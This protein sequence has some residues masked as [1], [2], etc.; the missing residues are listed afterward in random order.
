MA[1]IRQCNRTAF[2]G[3]V[4]PEAPDFL[5]L[6]GDTRGL[7]GLDDTLVQEIE[8]NLVVRS[9]QAFE[10]KFAPVAYSFFSVE[11]Q[12][13]IYTLERP[14][15]HIIPPDYLTEIPL[16]INN[17]TTGMMYTML[18]SKASGGFKNIE[19]AYEN[20]LDQISPKKMVQNVKQISKELR[21]NYS[22]YETLPEWDPV[23]SKKVRYE[24]GY[25]VPV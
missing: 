19:F 20:I 14:A 17:P 10:R 13:P 16:G 24:S 22:K 1:D 5:T 23:K 25:I 11:T 6:A 7:D 15:P 9:Y 12:E 3:L 8:D 2:F 18:D 21:H 4:N